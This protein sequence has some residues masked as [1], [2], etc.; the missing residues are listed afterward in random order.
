MSKT[1]PFSL[2][3]NIILSIA[4]DAWER[5]LEDKIEASLWLAVISHY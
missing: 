5:A 3:E 2:L 4:N 1:Y